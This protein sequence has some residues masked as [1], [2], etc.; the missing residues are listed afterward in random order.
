VGGASAGSERTAVPGSAVAPALA[1]EGPPD[2]GVQV[3]EAKGR[4]VVSARASRS[5]TRGHAVPRSVAQGVSRRASRPRKKGCYAGGMSVNSTHPDFDASLPAWLRARD[6]IAGEDVVKPAGEK[7]LPRLEAQTDEEYDAY[8]ARASL[9]NATARTADGYLGLL[10]CRAPFIKVPEGANALGK[11]MRAFVNDADMLG[12]SF[13]S[14]ARNVAREVIAVGCAG[15]LMDWEGGPSRTGQGENRVYASLYT[16]ENILN[17]RV[18]RIQ[19][20][21]VLT[22]LVLHESVRGVATDGEPDEFETKFGEQIRVLKLGV[23]GCQVEVWRPK[24]QRDRGQRAE[25]EKVESLI[26]LRLGKPLPLIPFVFHGASHSLA[27]V[28][29]LPLGDVIAVN[30]DHYRLHADYRHGMH[31]TALP[32]AWVS[33]FDKAATLRIGSSTAWVTDTPGASAG[34]LEYTGQGLTTFE[35]AMDRD[36][37]L[38]AILGARLLETQKRVGETAE[39]IEL[40]VSGENSVLGAMAQAMSKSLTDVLRW[41]YW[42]NCTEAWPDDVS[43]EQA[44]IELN[45]D[46]STKGLSANELTAIVHAWQS[47]A[48]S[49]DSMLD[50]FRRGEVLPEGRTNEEEV[51]LIEG[52]K[53]RAGMKT[54]GSGVPTRAGRGTV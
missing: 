24:Q 32:T 28:D 14:Y 52:E 47:G 50:I 18:E 33:G 41:A 35:R 51:R 16:A 30:L 46:Y 43:N 44:V 54:E 6:V 10:F 38:M 53:V 9:F 13:A 45:T 4:Q 22:L 1:L 26:P 15:T 5:M 36:E 19:G 23:G 39:A 12:M 29:R 21:N 27:D 25:W 40:R 20:R 17:W 11:A 2:A 34:F 37:K 7:Y 48:L 49:R 8:R 3:G 31:F 42:W